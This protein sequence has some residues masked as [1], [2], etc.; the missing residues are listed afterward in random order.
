MLLYCRAVSASVRKHG[1][2]PSELLKL[3]ALKEDQWIVMDDIVVKNVQNGIVSFEMT[4]HLQ[5]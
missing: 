1:D 4:E 3:L 5:R 2:N